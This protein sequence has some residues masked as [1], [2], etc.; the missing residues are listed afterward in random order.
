MGKEKKIKI[1]EK[2]VIYVAIPAMNELES[3]PHTINSIISQSYKKFH[4]YVC[5]NQPEEWWEDDEKI[6][7]CKNNVKTVEYLHSIS[8]CS[9]TVIDKCTKGNGWIPTRGGVGWARKLVMD[10][11]KEDSKST[12]LII[13]LDAD[14]IFYSEYFQSIVDSFNEFPQITAIS[15]PYYHNL[16][17][18]YELDRAML[19]YEIYMRYYAINMHR[20]GSPYSFTALGSAIALPVWVYVVVS[21]ITPKKA[22]ED[23]YF[24]QKLRKYGI[25]LNHNS[26]KVHPKTRYSDRVDFG[27]GPALIKG[28]KGNWESYPIYDYKLFDNVETTYQLF[29]DLF[30]D[31]LETPMTEFLYG[32]FKSENIWQPLRQN[33]NTK[34]LFVKACHSKVDGLRILQYLKSEQQKVE[35]KDEDILKD[36]MLNFLSKDEL[37]D[38]EYD[39]KYLSFEFS[40]NYVLNRIRNLLENVEEKLQR[41]EIKRI[42][43][44]EWI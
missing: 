40:N 38:F 25:V 35:S 37:K 43:E 32:Q 16:E 6:K 18:N 12:D 33:Y 14:T 17:K 28:S 3:L 15:V 13:S 1:S 22:G 20:I 31:D 24:L 42:K 39:L 44:G 8:K 11:I 9:V 4:V 34:K 30:K 19:R 41:K 21:G 36:F 7:I 5:V 26:Q 2:P 23:F 27:T 29:N 10:K